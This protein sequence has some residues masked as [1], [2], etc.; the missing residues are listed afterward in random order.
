MTP[1][2]I[3][4]IGSGE[5]AANGGLAFEAIA[6]RYPSPLRV[7][8][9]ETPAGFEPN[10]AAVAGRVADFMARRLQNHAAEISVIPARRRGDPEG[11]D[12]SEVLTPLVT[13]DLIYMGAGSP[14]YA[15]RQLRGTLAWQALLARH[16]EGAS[17]AL[18]SAAAM[19]L[20]VALG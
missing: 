11:P 19:V 17:I 1:G 2:L 13:A 15:A 16:S 18:A 9:L 20:D 10:S 8:I 4:L 3:A 5:T 7:A 6:A 12:I 14:T